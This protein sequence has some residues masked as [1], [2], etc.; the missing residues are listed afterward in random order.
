V[1]PRT[2]LIL[3]EKR[4]IFLPVG[5]QI[6]NFLARGLVTVLTKLSQPH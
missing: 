2:N 6:P 3:L 1:D 5:I 4:K